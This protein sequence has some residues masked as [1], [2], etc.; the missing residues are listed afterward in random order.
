MEARGRLT[1]SARDMFC[2]MG[3]KR[4][5]CRGEALVARGK[6]LMACGRSQCDVSEPPWSTD[7]APIAFGWLLALRQQPPTRSNI[8]KRRRIHVRPRSQK[9][10]Y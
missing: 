2:A 7:G 6:A 5:G 10:A 3:A 8:D 1:E 4:Y 9:T